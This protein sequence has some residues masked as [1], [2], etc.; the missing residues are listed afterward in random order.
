VAKKN[1]VAARVSGLPTTE[2]IYAIS[3]DNRRGLIAPP[4]SS[5]M[6]IFVQTAVLEARRAGS[7]VGVRAPAGEGT[8][9]D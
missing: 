6:T 8:S 1:D 2:A 5:R 7:E 4:S 9:G 3:M